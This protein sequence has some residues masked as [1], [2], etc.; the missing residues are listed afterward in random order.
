MSTAAVSST[1][2]FQ[3]L[4]SFYQNRQADLK[5]L[6]SALQSGDLNGAQQ[7]YKALAV[8][9]EGGPFAN[10]EP[11][12]KSSR[13]QAFDAVGEALQAGDLARAQ[14]S[15]ATL[16]AGQSNSASAPQATPAAVV[17][18]A[19][20]QPVT[21][22][23]VYN[24]SSIYQQLQTYQQ[25]RQADVAQLGQDLQA[26]NLNAAQQDFNTLTTL[27]QSGPNKNG[28]T[29]QQA[30]RAQDFQAIGQALQ[31]GDLAAAQSAFASLQGTFGKQN[32][33]S[34]SA[35]SA[36]NSNSGVTEIVINLVAPPTSSTGSVPSTQAPVAATPVTEA[37]VTE[38]P[39]TGTTS[40]GSSVPE[41]VINLGAA[42]LGAPSS[43]SASSG[44]A[45]PEIIINL[46]QGS[47]SSAVSPEEVTINFGSGTS[48]AQVSIDATQGQ[49]GSLADQITIDLNQQSANNYE[50]ILNLL[51]S[52]S[53]GQ[54]QSS[55]GNALS[56][57][58]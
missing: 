12:A 10:S 34:Q 17:N 56:V 2:I 32:Q 33:P 24:N 25:Q 35:I 54:T 50:V 44:S 53:T 4:Q 38:A 31:S 37:P 15:F 30:N 39:S 27:G 47:N 46:G 5:Q 43:T 57:S 45:T 7:A 11:F 20:T 1:S 42:N 58:A 23:P 3:E 8:L 9:G 18:L 22:P 6:S 41:I 21:E 14:A 16:T 13:A 26:G 29:F 48:G 52:G 36:Y 51:N 40:T 49:N 55:S 19:S 28:Q